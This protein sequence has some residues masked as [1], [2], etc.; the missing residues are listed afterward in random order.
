MD[1]WRIITFGGKHAAKRPNTFRWISLSLTIVLAF[2]LSSE[3]RAQ[4]NGH[5]SLGDFGLLSGSLPD[6][7]F[8]AAGFYYVITPIRLL[9]AMETGSLFRRTCPGISQSMRSQGCC[10]M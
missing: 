3:A 1:K 8:Y 6:P 9:I 7:G 10:G 4:L 2:M 5:N